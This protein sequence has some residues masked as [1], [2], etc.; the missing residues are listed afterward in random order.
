[1]RILF[2]TD[3][4]P[5]E[6]NAPARRTYE[7]A[8]RWIAAGHQVTVIT[9]APN[10]PEGQLYPGYRN[11]W[12]HVEQLD[13]IRVVRV[14]T[15]MAPNRGV[16]RRILDYVSFLVSAVPTSVREER[17][18]VVI[19]TSPQIFAAVAAWMIATLRRRPFV[20]EVRDLWP[21]S[22]TAVGAMRPSMLLRVVDRAVLALYRRASAIVVVTE[23]FRREISSRGIAL[24]RIALVR[25]AIDT[26]RFFPQPKDAELIESLG[27]GGRFVVGYVG[28]F[29]MAHPIDLLL[30][31]AERLQNDPRIAF[32]LVGGGA[33]YDSIESR[34]AARPLSNVRLVPRQ[35]TE[36]VP[37]YLS[38]CD[39]ATVLLKNTPV[40]S[41]V[42]PSKVF[43][44]VGMGRR[45]LLSA[46]DGE[47][48]D[49]IRE[50]QL[51]SVVA[52]EDVDALIAAIRAMRDEPQS[53]AD[54]IPSAQA[55]WTRETC[56][57]AMLTVLLSVRQ[58][59]H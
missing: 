26:T 39:V 31:A 25:N 32:L 45:V 5:P 15:Y 52:P 11:H 57:A 1:V 2:L 43:E 51:G 58:S 53:L 18:D 46:P 49:L 14:K 16:V 33:G 42:L 8:V 21:A 7:H 3:N 34:L 44:A 59:T 40:F 27:L 37:R 28:T 41:T 4:F 10:F 47:C 54:P 20:F 23:S 13:G 19:G 48:T 50:H 22:I 17:P 55:L 6:G 35:P 9:G 56:A 24:D 29:G 30:D 36:M 12:R 38:C